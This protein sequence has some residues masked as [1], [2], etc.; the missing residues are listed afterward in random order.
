MC[1]ICQLP[2][3]HE[4][5]RLLIANYVDP[6]S[7]YVVQSVIPMIL[8]IISTILGSL[9]FFFRR[10]FR[11]FKKKKLIFGLVFLVLLGIIG[12][13]VSTKQTSQTV[14]KKR[15]V[16]LAFD[17]MDPMLTKRFMNEGKLPNLKKI[18]DT[19]DFL[20]L[21]TTVPPQSPV[22]W[23]S[24]STATHPAKHSVYDFIVRDPSDY[25]LELTFNKKR[26]LNAPSFWDFATNH[27]IPSYIF[28]LP[29]TYPP[30]KLLGTMISGMGTPDVIG[31]QGTA[32]LITSKNY[33][34]DSNLHSKIIPVAND[35]QINT[36]LIGPKYKLLQDVKVSQ[37]PVTLTRDRKKKTVTISVSGKTITVKEHDFS[38]WVPV[39]FP[40]DFFTNY[41]GIVR[42]YA[43]KVDPEI[44]VYVSPV[45]FNPEKPIKPITYPKDY[46]KTLVKKYGLF[47]T[48]GL[49]HDTFALDEGIFDDKAFWENAEVTTKE[50]EKIYFGELGKFKEGIFFGYF[51]FTDTL[52]HMFWRSMDDEN[53]D[54]HDA[55]LDS[56]RKADM[57]VGKTIK[58]LG[59]DDVLFVMSD[60]GFSSFDYEFDANAWLMQNGYLVLK[61]G[62]TEGKPLLEDID[63]R[64]T[65]AYA[66][67]YNGIYL[68]VSGRERDGI[69]K[70]KE[71]AVL[72]TEI[73]EKLLE[74][75]NPES[76]NKVV[77]RMY[78]GKDL[79]IM[80]NDTNAPDLF[81]GF[82]KGTR[83]SFASAVG[84]VGNT[85]IK[86]RTSKWSGDHLFD[87]SEVPGVLFI[88][89]KIPLSSARI[90]DVMPTVLGMFGV[91]MDGVDGKNLIR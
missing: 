21:A 71:I 46:T 85:P 36:S 38:G 49:P 32:S 19:G 47:S 18:A 39:T 57:I 62:K 16:V 20:P 41:N 70:R 3:T 35:D 68:N 27:Q 59:K 1:L 73:S 66:I 61:E 91:K 10:F 65:K 42:F 22:A 69:V 90:I 28:F 9:L 83:S 51:G 55:I 23:A 52:Q 89:K 29:D 79:G 48:L 43:K 34:N 45:N 15:V 67:G 74:L 81:I 78:T 88:N 72:Q 25:T 44:E 37:A 7:G 58:M 31:T 30:S 2:T 53:A 33:S 84:G 12:Y 80:A 17:G 63:F 86:K 82:Y 75:T 77:K 5:E 14:V 40:I 8:G 76:G 13:M 11:F 56:Y 24:F 6:G 50:R 64:K 4:A 54:Y 87:P 26:Q 60:H